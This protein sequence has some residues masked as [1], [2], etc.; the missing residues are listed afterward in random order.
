MTMREAAAV[1]DRR[2]LFRKVRYELWD[3]DKI[4]GCVCVDGY[5]GFDCSLRDCP[6]G[7]DPM[8]QGSIESQTVRTSAT[9]QDE[10]QTIALS[11]TGGSQP[12]EVQVIHL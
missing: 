8:S 7:S 9:H 5:A 12:D 11:G 4:Q 1:L 6:V 10:V 3:A 2:T